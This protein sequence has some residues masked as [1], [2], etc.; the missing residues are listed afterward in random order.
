MCLLGLSFLDKHQQFLPADIP[1]HQSR[2]FFFLR[3]VVLENVGHTGLRLVHASILCIAGVPWSHYTSTPPFRDYTR[4]KITVLLSPPNRKFP[5]HRGIQR[6]V[7]MSF[8]STR[9]S[10]PA[11]LLGFVCYFV[12]FGT[13]HLVV[14][15]WF[16]F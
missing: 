15:I 10:F 16:W 3:L 4:P 5:L 9:G 12:T 13:K 14:W 8:V 1:V 11:T 2:F 7:C 6:L